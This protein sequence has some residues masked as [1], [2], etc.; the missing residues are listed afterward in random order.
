M[1]RQLSIR[2]VVALTALAVPLL[3]AALPTGPQAGAGQGATAAAQGAP[4]KPLVQPPGTKPAAAPPAAPAAK[5][6]KQPAAKV[7]AAQPAPAPV[8]ASS[9]E[10]YSY[11]A[12]GRRDPFVSLLN[13]GTDPRQRRAEGLAGLLAA[14]VVLKGILQNRG[15][16]LAIVQGPDGKRQYI[17][18]PND[19][20]AD[21]VVKAIGADS[22]LILQEVNDPLS[23]TKQREIRKTLRA[24]EEVK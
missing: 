8:T 9:Q 3:A 20:F 2:L 16:Y 12:E 19:R 11:R 14:D 13:R 15:T 24:V 5:T 17:V 1:T 22:M 7:P 23:L 4:A 6:A 10:G 21:G 18:H